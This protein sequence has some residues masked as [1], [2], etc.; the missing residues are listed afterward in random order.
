MTDLAFLILFLILILCRGTDG[1][2]WQ[3]SF[4]EFGPRP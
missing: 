4:S 1:F 3:I 2:V